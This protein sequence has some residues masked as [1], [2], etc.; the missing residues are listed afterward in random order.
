[1]KR[2]LVLSFITL[3][4]FELA[5]AQ[6]VSTVLGDAWTGEVV[7]SNDNTREITIAYEVKGKSETFTG[8]LNEGYS[9]KMKDGTSHTLKVSEIPIGSRIRVFSKTKDQDIG[10]RKVKLNLIWRVDFLGKDEFTR[11]REQINVS[12]AVS[13]TLAESKDL[14]A[15]NPLKLYLAIEDP[16]ISESLVG[17][18]KKWN[19]D[20][21]AEYG[22]IEV[23]SDISKADVYLA[24][25]GGSTLIAEIM[26][27]AT[28]FL[29]LPKSDGL[30]V[31][32]KQAVVIN[33]DQYSSP[34]IEKE[35]EK[36]MK[37]RKK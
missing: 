22:S 30:E 28:V 3:I 26:P 18:V 7:A 37:A 10:G 14:P 25:Y 11:L 19:R 34:L 13:V 12:P 15:G 29:V 2:I 24:R 9:V 31:I 4:I 17:W 23:V 36:R 8:V 21:G 32:W 6:K 20:F 16:G 5:F 35:I 27:T 1:M 33:P